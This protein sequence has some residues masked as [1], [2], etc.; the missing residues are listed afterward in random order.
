MSIHLL[1]T[2]VI[3]LFSCDWHPWSF[4]RYGHDRRGSSSGVLRQPQAQ[5]VGQDQIN[6]RLPDSLRG[7]RTVDINVQAAGVS[8]NAVTVNIR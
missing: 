2:L 8:S 5:Y 1:T 6:V 3:S 4:K 7:R